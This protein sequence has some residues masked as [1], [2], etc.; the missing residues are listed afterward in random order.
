MPQK[1]GDVI[2]QAHLMASATFLHCGISGD[3]PTTLESKGLFFR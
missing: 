2:A 1:L 3:M